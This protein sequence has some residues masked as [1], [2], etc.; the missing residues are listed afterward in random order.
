MSVR[1][2]RRATY[3]HIGSKKIP[4]THRRNESSPSLEE[5]KE[6]ATDQAV[7]GSDPLEMRAIRIL[8]CRAFVEVTHFWGQIEVFVA[9]ASGC[10]IH[11]KG[12]G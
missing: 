11:T 3:G 8:F 4:D 1:G 9:F 10:R 7:D 6:S 2:G 12:D 5:G